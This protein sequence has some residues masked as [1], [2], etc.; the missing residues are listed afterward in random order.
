M[1]VTRM[2]IRPQHRDKMKARKCLAT[3][4]ATKFRS[5]QAIGYKLDFPGP[6]PADEHIKPVAL[7]LSIPQ[8]DNPAEVFRRTTQFHNVV[9]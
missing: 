2:L 4:V 6:D 7:I 3:Y 8:V 5:I 1:Y 9:L